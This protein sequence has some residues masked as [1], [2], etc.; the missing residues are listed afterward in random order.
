MTEIAEEVSENAQYLYQKYQVNGQDTYRNRQVK[1]YDVLSSIDYRQIAWL[2]L[3]FR[4]D[5]DV[6]F[7][8]TRVNPRSDQESTFERNLNYE[9]FKTLL[10]QSNISEADIVPVETS[11]MENN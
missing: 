1:D 4:Y 8:F 9:Q 10:T 6:K 7:T 2:T 5:E 3:Y 11:T